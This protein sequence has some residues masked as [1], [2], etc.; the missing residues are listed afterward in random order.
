MGTV[1]DF[2]LKKNEDKASFCFVEMSS[3]EEASEAISL[4]AGKTVNDSIIMVK[5]ARPR[6]ERGEGDAPRP[7]RSEGRNNFNR[8]PRDFQG[9]KPT[10]GRSSGGGEERPRW[11]RDDSGEGHRGGYGRQDR[12]ENERG[13]FGNRREDRGIEGGRSP[14]T[15]KSSFTAKTAVVEDID[16]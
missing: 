11:K 10:F 9:A 7:E 16:Y 1:V 2:F 6:K 15:N 4:L 3:L 5:Y 13:G 14:V 12:F 8:G